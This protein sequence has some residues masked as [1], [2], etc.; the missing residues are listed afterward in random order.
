MILTRILPVAV[1]VLAASAVA[2]PAA[3]AEEGRNVPFALFGDAQRESDGAVALRS[4]DGGFGGLDFKLNK[5][6]SFGDIAVLQTTFDPTDDTCGAGSPRFQLNIDSDGDGRSDGNVFVYAGTLPSFTC[7]EPG[8]TGNLIGT[9]EPRFDTGGFGGGT[10]GY[11]QAAAVVGAAD[12]VGVQLVVD[13][14]F[15][16]ADGEQTIVV[17]PSVRLHTGNGR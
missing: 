9:A 8:D 14:G 2:A 10:V 17:N 16:Q 1:A 7:T 5:P 4:A 12:V 11:E 15:T 3:L 6:V 13:S